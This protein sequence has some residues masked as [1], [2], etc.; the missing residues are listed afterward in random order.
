VKLLS[1]SLIGCVL[2]LFSEVFA[3]DTGRPQALRDFEAFLDKEKISAADSPAVAKIYQYLQNRTFVGVTQSKSLQKGER[4]LGHT[5]TG[6]L[7]IG[8]GSNGDLEVAVDAD[9]NPTDPRIQFYRISFSSKGEKKFQV[10]QPNPPACA[11]CHGTSGA[12]I[13]GTYERWHGWLGGTTT[14][15][16][17][18][19]D[20]PGFKSFRSNPLFADLFSHLKKNGETDPFPYYPY[21]QGDVKW[22]RQPNTNLNMIALQRAARKTVVRMKVREPELFE[23]YKIP[24][25]IFLVTGKEPDWT[26][27]WKDLQKKKPVQAQRWQQIIDSA[28][29]VKYRYEANA[30]EEDLEPLAKRLAILDLLGAPANEI[31]LLKPYRGLAPSASFEAFQAFAN[32]GSFNFRHRDGVGYLET[33]IQGHLFEDILQEYPNLKASV[34]IHSPKEYLEKGLRNMS[35]EYRKKSNTDAA[36]RFAEGLA[37]I[38]LNKAEVTLKEGAI[39]SLQKLTPPCDPV[40]E[41]SETAPLPHA[42]NPK[43]PSPSH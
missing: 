23:K 25:G 24:L 30:G 37:Q 28:K 32:S 16:E 43:P 9:D 41:K 26:C 15:E 10:S 34:E 33:Y 21:S 42:T 4:F 17:V 36:M 39:G 29:G 18:H 7:F 5:P 27:F 11:R 6:T 22:D 20:D 31:M 1:L 35:E 14:L 13:A 2:L 38:G 3:E 12:F 40:S 8:A 19:A